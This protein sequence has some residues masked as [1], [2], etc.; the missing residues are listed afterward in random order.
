MVIRQYL[1]LI[2][3]LDQRRRAIP[4]TM[5]DIDARSGLQ[6]GYSAKLFCGKRHLGHLSLGL[7]LETLGVELVLRPRHQTTEKTD[8][9]AVAG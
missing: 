3:A 8:A 5:M 1:D 9:N 4:M 6:E 7:L 2:M